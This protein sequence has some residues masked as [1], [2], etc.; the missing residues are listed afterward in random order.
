MQVQN[1]ITAAQQQAGLTRTVDA[2]IVEPLEL[3]VE[4][5]NTEAKLSEGGAPRVEANLV[6]SLANRLRI[7]DYLESHPEL[8]QRSVEKPLFVFGLPRTGTTLVINL[9]SVDPARR[10]FLRWEAFDS[11]PPPKPEEL[12]AGPPRPAWPGNDRPGAQVRAAHFRH[13]P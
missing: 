13:S 3:L 6:S 11:V 5:L 2:S 4:A 12:H 9:L 10:C 7:E 1:I 8:L